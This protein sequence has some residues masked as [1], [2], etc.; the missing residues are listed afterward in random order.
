VAWKFNKRVKT[1]EIKE[2]RNEEK[3]SK[4]MKR[5]G[6]GWGERRKDEKR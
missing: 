3:G 2:K 6:K 5:T 1:A 4:G